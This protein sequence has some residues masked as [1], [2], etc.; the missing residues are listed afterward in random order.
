MECNST[1]ISVT[2]I[3]RLHPPLTRA[4]I[5]HS[6]L[7]TSF[8][9]STACF[10]GLSTS[11]SS[12]S[13]AHPPPSIIH[14]S[15]APLMFQSLCVILFVVLPQFLSFPSLSLFPHFFQFLI[16]VKFYIFCFSFSLFH[17]FS[18]S[19]V[20]LPLLLCSFS[21]PYYCQLRGSVGNR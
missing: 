16:A 9:P 21:C 6:S 8:P 2:V 5:T 11:S 18:F 10:S 13:Q 14:L 7:S 17:L 19:F 12:S 20:S 4:S 1:G 3:S 15:V